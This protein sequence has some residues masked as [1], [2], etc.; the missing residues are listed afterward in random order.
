M[1]AIYSSINLAL[2]DFCSEL[3][4]IPTF[5]GTGSINNDIV[6]VLATRF[7]DVFFLDFPHEL[8][9]AALIRLEN[10]KNLS[11][12]PGNSPD[13][14]KVAREKFSNTPILFWLA[15]HGADTNRTS[16]ADP[17]T[18]ILPELEAI[19]SL[20]P[21]DVL[22]IDD[23]RL[24][25]CSPTEPNTPKNWPD[26]SDLSGKLHL[27]SKFHRI[28]ILNDVIVFY[29]GHL[30]KQ[31]AEYASKTSVNWLDM[32]RGSKV[33]DIIFSGIVKQSRERGGKEKPDGRKLDISVVIPTLNCIKLLPGHL[34]SIEPWISQ[35][36]EVIVIDSHSSDGTFE[37]LQRYLVHP[38]LKILTHP[39]GLY[40]SWNF[41][42]GQ[43]T[44]KYIYVS[45]VGDSI[46]REH[47]ELLENLAF[48]SDADVVV[49][50]PRFIDENGVDVDYEQWPIHSII[51][52]HP[53]LDEIQLG[54]LSA[55][56]FSAANIPCSILGSSASN[57]YRGDFLRS[58]P[59]PEDCLV[60]GDSAWSLL[61]SLDAKF[62]LTKKIGSTFRFHSAPPDLSESGDLYKVISRLLGDAER[63]AAVLQK[64]GITTENEHKQILAIIRS[65][66]AVPAA[67]ESFTNAR[68]KS[69]LPWFFSKTCRKLKTDKK[70]LLYKFLQ[71]RTYLLDALKSNK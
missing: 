45:T 1:G 16:G 9:A 27:L 15:G 32:V 13:L 19:Q 5:A 17:G 66:R 67:K 48:R 10:N 44:S 70:I 68:R 34:E 63:I 33:A 3:L 35:V 4:S 61:H 26:L 57:L 20:Y 42:I 8:H 39:R 21:D 6:D 31:F 55:F 56:L 59:F 53:E 37:A 46:N 29:P 14:L 38:N 2:L 40:Q 52:T 71:A 7:K 69:V 49:S 24:Y 62:Y 54:P 28:I 30:R 22:L 43:T 25:L 60:I 65:Y 23:A 47:L 18:S 64:K 58:R 36:N 51:E 11:I 50:P 12:H 41:G